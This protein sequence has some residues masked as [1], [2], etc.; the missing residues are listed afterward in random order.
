LD[1][2]PITFDF[3]YLQYRTRENGDHYFRGWISLYQ[4]GNVIDESDIGTIELK[5]A[6]GDT[7][8]IEGASFWADAYYFGNWNANASNVD[9]SPTLDSG[10]S[11]RFND[12][13]TTLSPGNY[14]Y[15]VTTTDGDLL[16]KTVYYPGEKDMPCVDDDSMAYEWQQ[17]G[18]LKLTW[19]PPAVTDYDE[20]RVV[21]D[22]QDEIGK[23]GSLV[24]I[25]LPADA[26]EVIIPSAQIQ[27]IENLD[28]PVLV[29]WVVKTRSYTDDRNMYAR[30]YSDTVSFL[31][32][33]PEASLTVTGESGNQVDLNGIW[34]QWCWPEYD[35]NES[36]DEATTISGSSFT[37]KRYEWT[38]TTD[39]SGE[40]W[41]E[42]VYSGT[43]TLG[44]EVMIGSDF[45]D[46]TVTRVDLDHDAITATVY[47]SD[48]V[49][50]LNSDTVCGYTDWAIGVSKSL[51]G[52]DCDDTAAKDIIYIDDTGDDNAW[53]KGC[54][55]DDCAQDE[56]YPAELQHDKEKYRFF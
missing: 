18:S 4:N 42:I 30:G 50:E 47:D 52:T 10:F 38:D 12:S 14:T 23:W 40:P 48:M 31:W 45:G 44:S 6:N 15:E 13:L 34:R 36:S 9:F 5:D 41:V 27:K 54:N 21:F 33:E 39:C 2:F 56:G 11:I 17:D 24:Y 37:T 16:T 20:I 53:Y 49:D 7:I 46:I 28:D 35:D 29:H 43:A 32:D 25:K 26:D 3:A 1:D 22:D 51:M 19:D 8:F 55:E